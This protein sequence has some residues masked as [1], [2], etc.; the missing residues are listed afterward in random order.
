MNEL[1]GMENLLSDLPAMYEH[2]MAFDEFNV[3][4]YDA[5][6]DLP[7]SDYAGLSC[8]KSK[9]ADVLSEQSRL[10]RSVHI[11][12]TLWERHC[13]THFLRTNR[14]NVSCSMKYLMTCQN[15]KLFLGHLTVTFSTVAK[16]KLGSQYNTIHLM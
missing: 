1:D 13:W 12:L 16:E 6:N 11:A 14:K 7:W 9:F 10:V 5:V 2:I 4:H 15:T 3:K 8:T